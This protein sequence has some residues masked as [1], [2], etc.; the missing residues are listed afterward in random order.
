MYYST[1]KTERDEGTLKA[2]SNKPIY[3]TLLNRS[4]FPQNGILIVYVEKQLL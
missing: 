4:L 2:K 1:G 3:V